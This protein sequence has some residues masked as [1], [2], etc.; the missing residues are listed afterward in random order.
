MVEIV[1]GQIIHGQKRVWSG[2]FAFRPAVIPRDRNKLDSYEGKEGNE[3][4]EEE[5]N[6]GGGE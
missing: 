5:E 6:G 4:I 2:F 1:H 3:E